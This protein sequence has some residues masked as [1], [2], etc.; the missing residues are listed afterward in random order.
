[1][2]AEDVAKALGGRKAGA[3]WMARCPAH[4][5]RDPSLAIAVASSG[6]VLVHCHAGCD[7]RDVIA[8]LQ[9][10]GAWKGRGQGA[11]RSS[12]EPVGSYQPK[13]DC[14]AMNRTEAALA[15]WRASH[16]AEATQVE[17]YLRSRGLVIPVPPSIRFHPGLKHPSG[18]LWPAM[19]ALLTHDS[20][21]APIAI[22]RTFLAR[23]GNG[24]APVEPA[25]MMLGRCRGGAVRLAEMAGVLMVG[26]GIETCLAATQATGHPAW[27]ALS[28]SGMRALELPDEA[29]DVIVLADG[30]DAG[31][32]AARDCARR[33]KREGRRVRIARP[34]WGMDFN[35]LLMLRAPLN[36]EDAE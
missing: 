16:L 34:P 6:K 14:D 17:T 12:P 19:I 11:G 5:D 25:R 26:E 13:S 3:V 36:Q 22:H 27:A 33:W 29:G 18:A 32:A 24:K 2:T 4:N 35:D 8:A 20:D 9:L 23:D 28:T 30:D 21:E 7:Q 15:V 31:E 10:Q 1:M